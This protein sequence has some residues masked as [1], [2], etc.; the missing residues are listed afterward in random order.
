VVRERTSAGRA[1]AIVVTV[2]ALVAIAV[3]AVRGPDWYLRFKHPLRYADTI[4]ADARA[5]KLD[6]YLVA[7]LINVESGFRPDVVSR[8][9]AVGLMQVKPSTAN[10]LARQA[11][12]PPS[13]TA[14]SMAQPGTNIH[15]GTRYLAYLERRYGGDQEFALAAYNAG[16][17]AAD[18]WVKTARATG[19]PFSKAITFPATLHYVDEVAA[20]AKVYRSLYPGA[21]A[22]K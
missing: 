19:E 2:V 7:A 18:A 9:G 15:V 8:A 22:T 14:S 4:A 20:Q 17:T 16:M 10:A 12:L 1:V 3:V 13:E 5:T 21:F 6:P 11:S